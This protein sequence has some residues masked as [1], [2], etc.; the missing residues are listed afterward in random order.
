MVRATGRISTVVSH[1]VAV[2]VSLAV[3]GAAYA[4]LRS[5][6]PVDIRRQYGDVLILKVGQSP[7]HATIAD[8]NGDGTAD[9]VTA[10]ALTNTIQVMIGRGNGTFE[11]PVTYQSGGRTTYMTAVCDVD[12]DGGP[13]IVATNLSN[14][15]VSI[16][17]NDR[18]A[19]FGRP[20]DVATDGGPVAIACG[21][22]SGDGRADLVTA[23]VDGG[24]LTWL[25]NR[26]QGAFT[27]RTLQAGSAGA[28]RAIVLADFD[29]DGRT[30]IA[31]ANTAVGTISVL[32]NRGNHEFAPPVIVPVGAGPRALAAADVNGDGLPDLVTANGDA[33]SVS[34]A[35]N[36][37]KGV[38]ARHREFAAR[39]PAAISVADV[40]RDGHP[41]LLVAE[42]D[43]DSLSVLPGRG[44]GSFAPAIAI[45]TSGRQV[46][47]VTAADL[48]HD[49]RVDLVASNAA[50]GTVSIMLA[51]VAV[52]RIV[53][54]SPSAKE[55]LSV[56]GPA[57][58]R[59][60]TFT[61]NTGLDEST[62]QSGGVVAY[63]TQSG[64]H[65]LEVKYRAEA[66]SVTIHPS[67]T[68]RFHV[69]EIVH[70]I[71]TDRVRS[72]AGLP[73]V[74]PYVSSF[75]VQ[76]TAGSGYLAETQEISCHKIPGKL[77]AVDIDNDGNVDIVAL[78]REVDGIRVHYNSGHAEFGKDE[79]FLPTGGS[80]PWDLFAADLDR[81]G[82]IDIAVVNT[83]TSDLSIFYNKGHREFSKPI[84][85]ANGAGPMGVTAADVNGDGFL[86]LITVTK[87]MPE[88]FVLLNDQHGGFKEATRYKVAPSP[89]DINAYDLN[90]DGAVDLVMT[91]L[92][93]DRGTILM[94]N[95]DG[96]FRSPEE[97][98]LLLAK[99]LVD[100]PIDVNNDG[101]VD[102]VTVNTA[103]DDISIFLNSSAGNFKKQKNVPV[104]ATPTDQTFGDFN[105]DG[106]TDLAVTL[107]GGSVAILLNTKTGTFQKSQVIPVGKN[108][109]SIVAADFDNDGALDVMV[110]NQ[111]SYNLSLLMNRPAPTGSARTRSGPK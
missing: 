93:S 48:N 55:R 99:A 91:N 12:G 64:Y 110:A 67:S 111:Y 29:H 33:H 79:I 1:A 103:S 105:H 84:K 32:L 83:F 36:Q 78:C 51:D 107:D 14:S 77:R 40:D 25:V 82:L 101:V 13:D 57:L 104:G 11:T 46:T 10:S 47:W 53:T 23:N 60:I 8:L 24:N 85:I 88:V 80:G 6:G 86:D 98:P 87:G 109:K 95:G 34:V 71:L 108:P 20:T 70:V 37:G 90:G 69:G 100:D 81:D 50:S 52:P 31:V 22:L 17:I 97:F 5:A 58:D 18:T 45:G 68:P 7:T 62:L 26:G 16:F 92:E 3:F 44:D 4:E 73:L 96:T 41:D 15:T 56:V 66:R 72:D 106:Y 27:K 89:Y 76:P 19:H 65:A 74:N 102:M 63:G 9:I 30:D 49:G 42:S 35:L 59:D 2:S 21:D 43:D 38:F 28:P 75:V 94:N 54:T 61:F 39:A